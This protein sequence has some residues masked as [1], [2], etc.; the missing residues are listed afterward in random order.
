MAIHNGDIAIVHHIQWFQV[1]IGLVHPQMQLVTRSELSSTSFCRKLESRKFPLTLQVN[2]QNV[3]GFIL[4]NLNRP[5]RLS[6]MVSIVKYNS[7][8]IAPV[9]N[10]LLILRRE[11]VDNIE[12][13]LSVWRQMPPKRSLILRRIQALQQFYLSS[14][15]IH[16]WN[17][18]NQLD[19]LVKNIL[20]VW[21]RDDD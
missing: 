16:R 21:T 13:N 3:I 10:S 11:I 14:F 9:E 7:S 20:T 5:S 18:V 19:K 12:Y 6:A 15:R 1:S 2:V 8:K 17:D 4:A